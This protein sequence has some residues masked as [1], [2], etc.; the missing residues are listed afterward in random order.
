MGRAGKDTAGEYVG[1]HF[2]VKYP[3][4]ASWIVLPLVAHMAGVPDSQAWVER[5]NNR[6][7]WLN[8]CNAIRGDDFAC[9]ARW[10]LGDGDMAIGL[11]AK[12]EFEQIVKS[13][14]IDWIIWI[15]NPRVPDDITVECTAGSCDLVIPNH[16]TLDEFYAKLDKVMP[17][18]LGR[19]KQND[20]QLLE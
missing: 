17:A 19:V 6:V 10:C 12:P 20:S 13:R 3:R 18:L 4:S 9:L 16:G 7:F 8:A 5:H 15:D 1:K 2:D 11:R 14:M